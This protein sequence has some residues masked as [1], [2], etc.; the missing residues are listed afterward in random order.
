MPGVGRRHREIRP[1][2]PPKPNLGSDHHRE[3]A[4]EAKPAS[5]SAA[6]DDGAVLPGDRGSR[7]RSR[8]RARSAS[9]CWPQPPRPVGRAAGR[10]RRSPRATL[11]RRRAHRGCH[12]RQTETQTASAAS[13]TV[14]G[15]PA[16][17]FSLTSPWGRRCEQDS[18][19]SPNP[20]AI[21]PRARTREAGAV[22]S[23]R[24]GAVTFLLLHHV[25]PWFPQSQLTRG[26]R[27]GWPAP[28]GVLEAGRLE[29]GRH[30]T[31]R[32]R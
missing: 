29:H 7:R 1:S 12:G 8:C 14:R 21:H 15:R 30:R 3:M 13:H 17:M 2:A 32:T 22:R 16:S 20:G 6:S 18:R 31:C 27:T 9:T 26:Y 10:G 19:V 28:R 24:R 4:A 11:R 25:P 5:R 23:T